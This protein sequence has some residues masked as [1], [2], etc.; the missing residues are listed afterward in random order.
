MAGVSTT[1]SGET[2]AINVD[3]GFVRRVHG[4]VTRY[5]VSDLQEL[6]RYIPGSIKLKLNVYVEVGC[7]YDLKDSGVGLSNDNHTCH[8][9]S[10]RSVHGSCRNETRPTAR[11]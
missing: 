11:N 7:L 5:V 10:T 1:Y 6:L 8:E 2:D 9:A 4:L 3:R